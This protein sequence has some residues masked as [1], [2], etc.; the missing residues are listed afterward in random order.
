[1]RIRR[2]LEGSPGLLGYALNADLPSKTFWTVSA[3]TNDDD[4][5]RFAAGS[6]HH[7]A[8]NAMRPFMGKPSFLR[9][10]C[11]AGE[12]PIGWAEVRRRADEASARR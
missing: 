8:V 4:M 10:T 9:W 7:E 12:L 5:A 3:W 2:Q 11:T 6:P 1:M